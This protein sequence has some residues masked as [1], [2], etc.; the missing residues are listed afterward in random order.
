MCACTCMAVNLYM[1]VCV[2]QAGLTS[3]IVAA[4][5]QNIEVVE[6]LLNAGC[7]PNITENVSIE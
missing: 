4:Y 2:L 7:D 3:L 1:Y 6:V 5:N